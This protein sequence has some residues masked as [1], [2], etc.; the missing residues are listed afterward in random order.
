MFAIDKPE[1]Y[2]WGQRYDLLK[3]FLKQGSYGNW[4]IF[5]LMSR[6]VAFFGGVKT[7]GLWTD[8]SALLRLL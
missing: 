4:S 6:S 1:A 3:H 2:Y 7:D 5:W 8:S